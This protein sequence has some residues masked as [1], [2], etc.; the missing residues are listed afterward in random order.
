MYSAMRV[1]AWFAWLRAFHWF[2]QV[3]AMS[4]EE[5]KRT[6]LAQHMDRI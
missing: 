4:R 5:P 3:A 6:A 2:H 1:V